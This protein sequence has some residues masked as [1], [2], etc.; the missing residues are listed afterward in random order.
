VLMNVLLKN[1]VYHAPWLL[2]DRRFIELFWELKTGGTLDLQHPVTFNEKVNWLKLNDR[3]PLY[4]KLVDKSEAKKY[5][6]SVLGGEYII[7][8][9]GIWDNFEHIDFSSLPSDGFVLKCTH[10]SGSVEIIRDKSRMDIRNLRKKFHKSLSENYYWK[11]RE[12]PYKNVPARIIAEPYI[13]T[14]GNETSIEYKITCFDG[15]LGF[16]TICTGKAHKKLSERKN[17]FYDADFNMLPFWVYYEH[18]ANPI[19]DKPACLD[20]IVKYAEKMSE[21]IPYLRVDFY[22]NDDQILFGE[23][24]FYTWGGF[25]KFEPKEWD[26]KLGSMLMLPS[27]NVVRG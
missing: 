15:K 26:A 22:V 19:T 10:D 11:Y 21:G 14:L 9:L 1:I 24:T 16:S 8:T 6:A 5:V 17:D 25:L 27:N 2:S 20:E 12:W 7:P 4:T 3:N 13:E 18:S 23:N